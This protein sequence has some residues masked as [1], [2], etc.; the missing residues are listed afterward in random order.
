[1]IAIML[2][3]PRG[4]RIMT[5]VNI[6]AMANFLRPVFS[7]PPAVR[8]RTRAANCRGRR[9]KNARPSPQSWAGH[10][11]LRLTTSIRGEFLDIPMDFS[12]FTLAQYTGL[13]VDVK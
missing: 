12:R 13:C 6:V 10:D 4:E 7:T 2:L 9:V 11:N 8:I 3:S 5:I 1:M